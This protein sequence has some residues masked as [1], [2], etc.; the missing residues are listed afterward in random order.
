MLSTGERT[1]VMA[2]FRGLRFDASVVG[3]LASVI[4]PPYDVLDAD[5]V[6]EL[7]AGNRRNIVRLILSRHFERPY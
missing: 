7:E 4:S 1:L 6:R 3:D 5:M 2:P